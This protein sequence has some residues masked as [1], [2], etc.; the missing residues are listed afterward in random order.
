MSRRGANIYKRKDGRWEGRIAGKD[1]K[2]GDRKYRSVY[3]KNYN[4]VKTKL[5]LMKR[6]L[7]PAGEPVKGSLADIMET[8]LREKR[9][10]WKKTTYAAYCQAA[11]KHI[12][13]GLG[14]VRADKVDGKALE[15]FAE[16]MRRGAGESVIS[17]GYLRNI[18]GIML[19]ALKFVKKKYNYAIE[20]PEN[21][22]MPA[23]RSRAVLP[24]RQ[25]LAVLE[26]YLIEHAGD[27]TCLGIL[28]A[29]YTGMRIGEICALTW[30]SIN[31]SE[32]VIYV[33]R[34]LQRVKAEADRGQKTG[35]EILVQT[36]KT[37]TSFRTIPIPPALAALLGKYRGKDEKYVIRGRKKEWVEPRTLQYR[38]AK[39]LK[40][41][42][43]ESF[44]FHMLRHA[45]ASRCI[46][47]GFDV[48]SVSEI[49]GHSS[50]QVTLNLYVHSSMEHKKEL[51]SKLNGCFYGSSGKNVEVTEI[52]Q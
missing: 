16:S 41:C 40:A 51:M 43:I 1:A 44:H 3:G 30:E 25:D 7:R 17:E 33:R 5:E 19:R 29:F 38:F 21:L 22:S 9:P 35:T 27:D 14:N 24:G 39:I 15:D 34:N 8:W 28:T 46:D 37:D 42:G 2:K 47:R 36:P 32:G 26:R 6:S 18:C 12:I 11:Y 52:C 49:L 31:F 48:K 45:F 23:R 20:I 4:E 13:P 10:A 50:V